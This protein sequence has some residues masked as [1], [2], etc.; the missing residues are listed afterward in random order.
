MIILTLAGGKVILKVN[1]TQPVLYQ[2]EVR[3]TKDMCSMYVSLVT[4]LPVYVI[5]LSHK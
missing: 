4:T 3:L 2:I 5:F 1:D